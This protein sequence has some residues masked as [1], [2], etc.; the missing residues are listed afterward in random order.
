MKQKTSKFRI[1]WFLIVLNTL[2]FSSLSF[3]NPLENLIKV[4]EAKLKVLFWNIYIASLYSKTG[5]YEAEQF[6]QA[7]KINYLRDI[8]S[9]ELIEKTKEEWEKLGFKELTF[10]HWIRLLSIIFPDIKKGDTLLL[11]VN[12]NRQSEFFFNGKTI[13]K[14]NDKTFGKSFLRIWLDKNCSFPEIR[15]KLIGSTK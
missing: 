11:N 4:G 15:K 3:A 13:G 2:V 14:I 1:Y 12:E 9:E 10:S 5:E 8:D 6:P 7:L